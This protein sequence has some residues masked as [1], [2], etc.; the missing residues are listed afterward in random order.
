MSV[1]AKDRKDFLS[2]AIS[3]I[4]NQTYQFIDVF[5]I[6]DGI[7]GED[8]DTL[9]KE[10]EAHNF[11]VI[12][13][14]ENKGLAVSL[15]ELLD[16][17][18]SKGYNYIARM[19]AD[20]ISEKDRFAKQVDYLNTHPEVDMIGGAIKEIDFYGNDRGKIVK[21]PCNPDD[22]RVFFAKRNPVA[23]PAVMFKKSF[24]EKTGCYY[25]TDF[26]RNEDTR[27]WLEGYKH[28]CI[29]ANIPD[30]ILKF[31][32]TDEMFKQRRNGKDFAK[33]Q[34]QL[35]KRIAKDL[36]FG[37]MAYIYAYA[38]YCLMISPSWILKLA[39]RMLR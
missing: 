12:R 39:Y 15:N 30:I 18:I 23:H 25:P 37:I 21:Y 13:R 10:K 19:D 27:L 7:I 3:S 2:D 9:L 33:S 38:T 31:R 14:K 11:H 29:I 34:L 28:G 17:V 6:C 8:L 4:L 22:C 20:D 32:V 26:V 36:D 5:L 1:Y 24:F 16:I 35:R